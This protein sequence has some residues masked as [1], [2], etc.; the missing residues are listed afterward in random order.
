MVGRTEPARI[1][2]LLGDEHLATSEQFGVFT[3]NF[4]AGLEAY[5]RQDWELARNNFSAAAKTAPT[6]LHM[7]GL[8]DIFQERID[9]YMVTPPPAD[10]DG[11]FEATKK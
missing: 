10:W 3:A 1:Y 8:I 2:A 7:E 11:V 4:G 6:P 5:R 9:A